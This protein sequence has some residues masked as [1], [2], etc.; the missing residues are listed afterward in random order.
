MPHSHRLLFLHQETPSGLQWKPDLSSPV[1]LLRWDVPASLSGSLSHSL[2]P[3]I[4]TISPKSL[5]F[6]FPTSLLSAVH[7]FS[8]FNSSCPTSAS[9]VDHQWVNDEINRSL[10]IM[11]DSWREG[12]DIGEA[13]PSM[14]SK[15]L[16]QFQD[17]LND[18]HMGCERKT[19]AYQ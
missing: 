1:C 4:N 5:S 8:V 12:V 14:L 7:S 11:M 3:N 2:F 17:R 19:H 15:G 9:P 6:P 18:G 10:V 16:I 13:G